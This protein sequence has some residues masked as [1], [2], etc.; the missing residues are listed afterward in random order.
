LLEKNWACPQ[1]EYRR[2]ASLTFQSSGVHE[3]FLTI[4]NN[5]IHCSEIGDLEINSFDD[6]TF[7]SLEGK[8]LKIKEMVKDSSLLISIKVLKGKESGFYIYYN[9]KEL[10][11]SRRDN[12]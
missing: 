12:S 8:L 2:K 1:Y 7:I 5:K 10:N 6:L 9:Q 11:P 3:F 4:T